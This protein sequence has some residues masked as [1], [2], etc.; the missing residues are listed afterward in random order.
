M[1]MFNR[2]GF[3]PT[4][5]QDLMELVIMRC[6]DAG[7]DVIFE[8]NFKVSTHGDL[9][10]R[11]LDAHPDDNYV[12][13]LDVSLDECIRRHRTRPQA[14]TE[15]KMAELYPTTT[16]LGLPGEVVVSQ[17]LAEDEVVKLIMSSAGLPDARTPS[18]R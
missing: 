17:N 5:D 7:I 10:K 13:Y 12:F 9:L 15:A 4:P 11:I 8:G 6:L 1:Q 2:W 14:I 3:E 16:P 18:T